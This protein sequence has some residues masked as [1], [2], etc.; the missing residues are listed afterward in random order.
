M[1]SDGVSIADRPIRS[2]ARRAEEI[3]AA[4]A[5]V[6]NGSSAA[7]GHQTRIALPSASSQ[8]NGRRKVYCFDAIHII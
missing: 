1:F 6:V 2:T 8:P 4:T 3:P 5:F 7:V